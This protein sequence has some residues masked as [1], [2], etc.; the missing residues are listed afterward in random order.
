MIV[1]SSVLSRVSQK[2]PREGLFKSEWSNLIAGWCVSFY[3]KFNKA[4]KRAIQTYYSRWAGKN[5]DK[6]VQ[7]LVEKFLVG[8]SSEYEK[9]G[10]GINTDY[11]LDVAGRYFNQVRVDRLRAGLEEDLDVGDI[12]KALHKI[13]DFT[14]LDMGMGSTIKLLNDQESIRRAFE[15]SNE[16]LIV[17]PGALGRFF[18]DAF[19]RDSFIS[20]LGPEKRGKSWWLMDVAWMAAEQRR[21]VA[22]FV[23]GDMSEGQVQ[24]RFGTRASGIPTKVKDPVKFPVKF[25]RPKMRHGLARVEHSFRRYKK[26]LTWRKAWKA[27]Q[28]FLK[29]KVRS[30]ESYIRLQVLPANGISVDGVDEQIRLWSQDGWVPDVVVVD[31]A[32]NLDMPDGGDEVRHQINQ[33]WKKMRGVAQR[34]HLCFVT[35][36]Q[37][38][39]ASYEDSL[40]FVITRKNFSEDKRKL[41]HVTGM[42][43]LNQ[44]ATERKLGIYR[45]NWVLRREGE[46]SEYRPVYVAGSLSLGRPAILSAL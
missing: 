11:V 37:A 4:P 40:S 14:K 25:L 9:I 5:A 6:E 27:Y 29:D 17:Y 24:M 36:T 33:T 43:G 7:N 34:W 44:T 46:F 41:A 31:Y 28:K 10:R 39:A 22:Y 23:L 26:A 30:K 8:L 35:A 2:W 21:K 42:I 13:G 45:L 3:K 19:Q 16:P 32:D 12:E 38:N 1:K 15:E 20:F 18:G